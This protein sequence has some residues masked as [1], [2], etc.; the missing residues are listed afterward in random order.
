MPYDVPARVEVYSSLS[1]TIRPLQLLNGS[2]DGLMH[3]ESLVRDLQYI[4]TLNA[5]YDM[6][7]G[8]NL[9]VFVSRL[10]T[11]SNFQ[12]R[13]GVVTITIVR[14]SKDLLHYLVVL[15]LI[16]GVSSVIVHL[17]FG[18]VAT[19]FSE[20]GHSFQVVFNMFGALCYV[21]LCL[22]DCPRRESE[23]LHQRNI[24]ALPPAC[25]S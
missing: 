11:L 25:Q 22:L 6:M 4:N 9:I 5:L 7:H 12:P 20:I 23:A 13:L 1:Q 8:L 21:V 10:L 24:S 18:A 19:P 3:V 14:C 17:V 15:G 16:F 2:D